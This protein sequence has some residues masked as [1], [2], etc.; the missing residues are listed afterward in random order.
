[1][2]KVEGFSALSQRQDEKLGTAQALLAGQDVLPVCWK[3]FIATKMSYS[4][5][6]RPLQT[7]RSLIKRTQI[8]KQGGFLN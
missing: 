2:L 8:S 1:M 4:K 5:L 7:L 3:P 6:T